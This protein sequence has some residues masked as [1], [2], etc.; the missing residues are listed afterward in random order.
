MAI[1]FARCEYVSRSSGGNACRKASYN[2]REQIRC[3]RTGELFSFQERGGNV[4]HEILIPLGAHE[5]FKNSTTL[6]NE[7]EACERRINSQL[8]KEFVI[9]LPDNKKVTLEDRIELTRRFGQIF[10]ERGVAVQVDVHSPHERERNWHAHL[11]VTTRRFSEDGLIFGEKARD[12]DPVVRKGLVVESNLWGE[13]WRD[14]QNAYFEEKGYDI[15]VDPIGII[16][17]EHIGPVRMRHHMN[18]AVLRAQLLQKANEKLA[19]DPLSVIEELTRIKAVFSEGDVDAFL[20]KHVPSNERDGLSEKILENSH[21]IPLYD[22]DTQEKTKYFTTDEV[23]VEEEKLLRFIEGIANTS[24][25]SLKSS[26]NQKGQIEK[27]L[28]A[29]QKE[30]YDHCVS[31][32]KNLILIQ[33]RAGVGKSYVLDAIRKAH[34]EDG[35]RVLGLAATHKVALDLKENGFIEA[36]TCHSFLFAFKN[37]RDHLNSKTLVMVDEAGMLGT[38]LSVELF[39]AIKSKGAKLILVGDDRQLSSVERGGSFSVLAERYN[40]VELKDV[41]RQTI[42]WQKSLSEAL[43]EGHVKEAVHYLNEN[44]AISWTPTKEEA[45]AGL[46][47]DWAKESLLNPHHSRLI[48][49]QQNIDVDA[50]NQGAR[51]ILRQQGRVGDSEITCSTSRGRASFAIG[52]RVQLTKTDQVQSLLNGSFGTIEHINP[53]TKKIT[54][55]LDNGETKE[56]DPNLYD[57]LRHGYAAT[58]Y[59]SQGST[60]DHVYVLYSRMTN[61]LINYVALTRQ[62]KSLSLYV[63]Q[64]EALSLT[65]LI[66]QMGR[67][68][69]QGMSL[70]FDTKR[71]IEKKQENKPVPIHLK[72]HAQQWLTK[73]ADHFHKNERFYDFKKPQSLPQEPATFSVFQEKVEPQTSL[74]DQPIRKSTEHSLTKSFQ[75]FTNVQVVEEALK[76][77]M[78][79]F[80]D[81]VFSSLGKSLHQASSSSTQR[82]Y[83][84]RGHITVNLRTGAWIDFRDSDMAGGPLH[85]LTKLKGLS[86]KEAVDYGAAWAGL[87]SEGLK[88]DRP[89]PQKSKTEILKKDQEN[90][91]KIAKV[92]ALWNKGQPIQG[93][94]AERYLRKHRKIEGELP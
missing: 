40:A 5:K 1:Q 26:S 58:V 18:E 6:W 55:H 32:N 35:Y 11:L 91:D 10:I 89:L 2:Q 79:A 61:S 68:D 86:F 62:T 56:I 39:H 52:D 53:K 82:R 34:E 85:L 47:K 7:V 69:T 45:L 23:R 29:E 73:V 46:L 38:T 67:L 31:S 70:G 77:N 51:E 76:Q 80:A 66:R 36:K 50:L 37:N 59:K 93:T 43:S 3:E 24:R 72:H 21:V 88:Y 81:D 30:A 15:R 90:K 83:G 48:L 87:T 71:D 8:A 57:G 4:H 25:S 16:P 19:Q 28:T 42:G 20:K 13:I 65:H 94:L 64:D 41:R 49:A 14:L 44:K 60:L 33:G 75:P 74:K 12:L 54:L 78:A 84:E 22:K 92:Q 9:A 63:S 17:Q 27:S